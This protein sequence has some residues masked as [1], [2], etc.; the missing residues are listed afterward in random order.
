MVLLWYQEVSRF[1]VVTRFW[2]VWGW[3][4]YH[5]VHAHA[6]VIWSSCWCR[7]PEFGYSAAE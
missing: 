5:C 7:C 1:G 3:E 2:K 6:L 4:A